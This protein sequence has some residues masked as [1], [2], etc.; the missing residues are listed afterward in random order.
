MRQV[1]ES[2]LKCILIAYCWLIGI[3][4]G[5]MFILYQSGF[6]NK[7]GGGI[8]CWSEVK[9]FDTVWVTSFKFSF[10]VYIHNYINDNSLTNE[11]GTQ[12][13]FVQQ[14]SYS[15]GWYKIKQVRQILKAQDWLQSQFT[16]L[17]KPLTPNP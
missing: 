7:D 13:V 15:S 9:G 11:L 6:K 5:K 16:M 10:T 3:R 14:E 17:Y 4:K 1:S 2:I 12:N 8:V